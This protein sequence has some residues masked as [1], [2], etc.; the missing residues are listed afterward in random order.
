MPACTVPGSLQLRSQTPANVQIDSPLPPF[1][2]VVGEVEGAR[3]KRREKITLEAATKASS[4]P[5]EF[6]LRVKGI[7]ASSDT[8][9]DKFEGAGEEAPAS[10]ENSEF[11][12]I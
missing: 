6:M 10:E 2:E 12:K 9:W 3:P 11:T 1:L 7:Q 4:T 8:S 5:H